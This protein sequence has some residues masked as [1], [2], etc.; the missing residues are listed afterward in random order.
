MA[1]AFDQLPDDIEALKRL[2]IARD[3]EVEQQRIQLDAKDGELEAQRAEV[4]L[5][6]LMIEK[7]K[8]EIARLRRIQFG[9]R[10]ERHDARVLQ[11][12]LIVEELET[13]LAAMPAP[14]CLRWRRHRRRPFQYAGHRRR[15]CRA[16]TWC[17]L[18]H[19]TARSAVA[20]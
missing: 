17:T 14:A 15:T 1:P 4:V 12:E 2:L 6:R 10:S 5:A 18:H 16:R 7:L 8:L 9:R 3:A 20:R 11:L 13:T 19:V